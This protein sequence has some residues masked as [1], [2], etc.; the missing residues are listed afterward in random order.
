MNMRGLKKVKNQGIIL[1]EI[2]TTGGMQKKESHHTAGVF[3]IKKAMLGS[4]M[5]L[6]TV[7]TFIFLV[8]SN[9]I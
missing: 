6:P 1:T 8:R 9:P 2:I 3:L 5:Q 7:I 4:M